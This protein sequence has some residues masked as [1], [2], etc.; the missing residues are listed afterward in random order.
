MAKW[1]KLV[2]DAQ[3]GKGR[4][5]LEFLE[6]SEVF[7]DRCLQVAEQLAADDRFPRVIDQ[8]AGSG[9][10]VGANLAEAAEAMSTKDFRKSLAIAN[11]ELVETRYWLRLI[12]RRKWI[13][14][15][16]LLPLL[17]ELA[18]IKLIIGSILTKTAPARTL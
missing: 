3:M 6:R 16:R 10:S 9:S 7:A 12:L 4:L 11:K 5:Q 17:A 13:P 1:P 18:E 8:L 2:I 14:D 15:S